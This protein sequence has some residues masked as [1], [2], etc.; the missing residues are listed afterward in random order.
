MSYSQLCALLEVQNSQVFTQV[1]H[2]FEANA[3]EMNLLL[4]LSAATGKLCYLL[5]K[6]MNCIKAF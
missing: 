5:K 4:P 1:Q 6:I 3:A 2:H